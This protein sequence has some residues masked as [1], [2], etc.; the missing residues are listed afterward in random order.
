MRRLLVLALLTSL[1]SCGSGQPVEAPRAPSCRVDQSVDN[2]LHDHKRIAGV[3]V[4]T[5]KGKRGSVL[6]DKREGVA[7]AISPERGLTREWLS[8][9]L[10]CDAHTPHAEAASCPLS[11]PGA[12]PSVDSLGGQLVVYVRYSDP[13]IAEHAAELVHDGE[14]KCLQHP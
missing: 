11:L 7:I 6:A 2:P 5:K 3:Q 13:K 9:V 14:A 12:R 1:I 10:D 8:H 4:L